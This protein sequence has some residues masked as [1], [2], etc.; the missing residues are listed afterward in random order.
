MYVETSSNNHGI[1]VFVSFE[2]TVIIQITNITFHSYR[3]SIL[4]EDSIKS[5]GCFR[6]R[7]LLE[8]NAWST[9]YNIAKNDRYSDTSTQ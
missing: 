1:N 5:M 9:R 2:R 4:T 7:L 6:I 3:F 8:D